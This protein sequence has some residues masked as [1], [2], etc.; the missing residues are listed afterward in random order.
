MFCF[1]HSQAG[2]MVMA[3]NF[4]YS[5]Y[6]YGLILFISLFLGSVENRRHE[7]VLKMA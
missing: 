7:N 6:S 3:A 4:V 1:A 2:H 5:S